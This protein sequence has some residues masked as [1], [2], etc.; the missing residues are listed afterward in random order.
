MVP[1]LECLRGTMPKAWLAIPRSVHNRGDTSDEP[2]ARPE[3][4]AK[5]G[6]DI[7]E[8]EGAWWSLDDDNDTSVALSAGMG[9]RER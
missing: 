7:G 5:G 3:V 9:C 2:T 1:F 8:V 4:S 6:E